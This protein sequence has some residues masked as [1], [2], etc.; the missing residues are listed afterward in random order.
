[1]TLVYDSVMD[2]KTVAIPIGMPVPA[3]VPIGQFAVRSHGT[4]EALLIHLFCA[5]PPKKCQNNQQASCEYFHAGTHF[6]GAT[7]MHDILCLI[8]PHHD[9]NYYQNNYAQHCENKVAGT[10]NGGLNDDTGRNRG[11]IYYVGLL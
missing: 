4:M 1:M 5:W 2:P 10:I 11:I 3:G 7:T 9:I 6:Q 8:T